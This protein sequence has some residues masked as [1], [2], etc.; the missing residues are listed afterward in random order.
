MMIYNRTDEDGKI[1]TNYSNGLYEYRKD[2]RYSPYDESYRYYR[3]TGT[4][5]EIRKARR[6]YREDY[7]KK[8]NQEYLNNNKY[9]DI[10]VDDI[11]DIKLPDSFRY[12]ST[13]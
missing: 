1:R 10:Y 8:K 7:G 11:S 12:I 3:Y 4:E 5:D 6:N 9:I 13:E 2:A